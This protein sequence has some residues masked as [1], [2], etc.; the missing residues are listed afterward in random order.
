MGR[1]SGS[2]EV[3][4]RLSASLVELQDQIE[5]LRH[6]LG[7]TASGVSLDECYG[8]SLRFQIDKGS[9]L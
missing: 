7:A 4:E 1:K 9:H 3:I 6:E 5:V 8:R 2:D